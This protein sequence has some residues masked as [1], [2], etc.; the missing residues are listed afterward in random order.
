[1]TDI[2]TNYTEN[3]EWLAAQMMDCPGI[4][5]GPDQAGVMIGDIPHHWT[6]CNGSGTV[7][8]FP[9]LSYPCPVL[10]HDNTSPCHL[11]GFER[12]LAKL[13]AAPFD[14]LLGRA[15]ELG[16]IPELSPSGRWF[17]IW[18]DDERS[19]TIFKTGTEGTNYQRFVSALRQAIEAS[20]TATEQAGT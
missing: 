9:M 17:V 19:E 16:W 15:R 1:M 3:I 20:I 13:T 10:Q 5:P 12:R 11:C 7:P 14:A 8:M 18:L 2:E 4:S 6:C